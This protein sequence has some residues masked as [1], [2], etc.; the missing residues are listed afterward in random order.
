[1]GQRHLC[2]TGASPAH[3]YSSVAVAS[4]RL[5]LYNTKSLDHPVS[6]SLHTG[7]PTLISAAT[8][9]FAL[10]G[11]GPGSIAGEVLK[12]Y[13]SSICGPK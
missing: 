7:C 12:S 3:G 11:T 2:F 5:V 9:S 6:D 13:T 10:P 8:V 4:A 1:M